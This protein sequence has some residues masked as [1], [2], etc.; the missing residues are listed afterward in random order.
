MEIKADKVKDL[1]E[2]TGVGM[3]ECKT[4]LVECQGDFEKAIVFLRERGLMSAAKRAGRVAGEGTVAAYIHA[5]GQIGVLLELNCETDFVAKTDEFQVLAREL[6]MQVAAANPLFVKKEDVPAE[7]IQR[8]R[9]IYETQMG[10]SKKPP[11]IR[12]KIL[13][14]KLQKYFEEVCLLEQAYIKDPAKKAG[15]LVTEAVSK[16]GENIQVR[17]FAR[18]KIGEE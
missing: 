14:G 15:Q 13:A 8:E 1:R 18:Y 10:D 7:I 16:T 17:R 3:M 9:G 11:E 2:K 6:A 4:A 12:E 5:G